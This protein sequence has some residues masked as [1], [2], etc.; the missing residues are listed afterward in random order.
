MGAVRVYSAQAGGLE[1]IHV[2]VYAAE[3][4]GTGAA[5]VR[6]YSVQ[7]G[8]N[9]AV[10]LNPLTAPAN[11]EPETAI[12]LTTTLTD[13]TTADSYMWRVVSGTPVALTGTGNTRTL[14]APSGMPPAGGT[15][16]IGVTATKDGYSS[17]ERTITITALPQ[18]RWRLAGGTW[19]G[20]RQPVPIE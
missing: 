9:A 17:V 18:L 16:T 8:G 14:R 19:V 12:T 20:A 11:P 1:V 10:I 7:A 2:R 15:V 5:K 4:G 3:A 6:V 13:G